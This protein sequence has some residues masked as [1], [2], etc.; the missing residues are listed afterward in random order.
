[1]KTGQRYMHTVN[2]KS[3]S[4]AARQQTCVSRASELCLDHDY[5]SSCR[6]KHVKRKRL[7]Q[8][9]LNTLIFSVR[10]FVTTDNFAF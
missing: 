1:M 2:Q 6:R 5:P 3:S 10:K 8:I 4:A 9:A 7:V